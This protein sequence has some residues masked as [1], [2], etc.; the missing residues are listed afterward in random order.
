MLPSSFAV[1]LSSGLSTSPGRLE[2]T[3]G[4]RRTQLTG[5][6]EFD[7]EQFELSSKLVGCKQMSIE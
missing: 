2:F 6:G 5:E 4:R 1:L 7:V 3:M